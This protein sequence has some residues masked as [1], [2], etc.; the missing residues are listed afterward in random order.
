MRPAHATR[1]AASFARLARA[2]A[3][4][5]MLAAAGCAYGYVTALPLGRGAAPRPHDCQVRYADL[6]PHE[7]QRLYEQVGVLCYSYVGA[8]PP[9]DVMMD[10]TRPQA[11]R[12]GGEVV[13]RHGICPGR[14]PGIELGVYVARSPGVRPAVTRDVESP[15]AS[16][17]AAVRPE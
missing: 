8:L 13:V 5:A 2:G 6:L 3:V 17:N 9:Q 12:L 10:E 16:S 7:A 4:A 14:Y 15:P 1:S 11:C